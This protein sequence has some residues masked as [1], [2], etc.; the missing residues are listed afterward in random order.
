MAELFAVATVIAFVC[1]AVLAQSVYRALVSSFPLQFQDDLYSRYYF[2]EAA[3]SPST[4]LPLQADYVKS[5][6][7]G[8]LG[9]FCFS[10]AC[11]SA[12]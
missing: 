1:S 3:L 5:L 6:A 12:G 4:P 11:F 8:C 9:M 2:P 7:A 10:L